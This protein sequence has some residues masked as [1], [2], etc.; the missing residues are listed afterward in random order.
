VLDWQVLTG[1]DAGRRIA[2][3]MAPEPGRVVIRV[4]RASDGKLLAARP[5][6]G[7]LHDFHQ[8][9]V[10]MDLGGNELGSWQPATGA[11]VRTGIRGTQAVEARHGAVARRA[12]GCLRIA[13]LRRD[14][15]WKAWCAA[16]NG[17]VGW[18]PEGRHVLTY[19]LPPDADGVTH[20]LV[21]R[22]ARAGTQVRAFT[23]YLGLEPDPRW[24]SEQRLLVAASD[25]ELVDGAAVVRLRLGGSVVR[26]SRLGGRWPWD[27]RAVPVSAR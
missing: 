11:V 18:S 17:F 14:A 5:A 26:V 16:E 8:G 13:P 24:E 4:L 15:D 19:T 7:Q 21:V 22:T 27:V 6:P 25:P 23:G 2:V 3:L 1:E 12:G 10:W 9:K 20:R